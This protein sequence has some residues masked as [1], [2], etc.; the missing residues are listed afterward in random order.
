ASM[1]D[2]SQMRPGKITHG[3]HDRNP[4]HFRKTQEDDPEYWKLVTRDEG[5]V[6]GAAS[7]LRDE[8]EL[9]KDIAVYF[10]MISFMDYQIGLILDELDR[11][12]IA[13]NTLVVFTTDHGHFLGQHGL[14]AKAIHH[15][16]D[17]ILWIFLLGVI[18]T[19]AYHVEEILEN[20]VYETTSKKVIFTLLFAKALIG[21]VLICFVFFAL[22]EISIEFTVLDFNVKFGEIT[23]LLIASVFCLWGSDFYK[24]TNGILKRKGESI[25]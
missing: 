5:A 12:G 15:Y 1:Y 17:L 7:H 16:E 2:P 24:V 8:E 20:K 19:I 10:G 13:E 9:K 14:T 3:E 4:E 22:E 6:H 11:L 25:K 18:L 21:G 23:N